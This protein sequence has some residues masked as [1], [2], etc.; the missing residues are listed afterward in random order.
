[1]DI[2]AMRS[3]LCDDIS[4]QNKAAIGFIRP[5]CAYRLVGD[6]ADAELVPDARNAQPGQGNGLSADRGSRGRGQWS[7]DQARASAA[8]RASSSFVATSPR[9]VSTRSSA[10]CHRS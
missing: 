8:A 5:V 9:R 1:M 7:C 10:A 6:A 4:G 2:A 3:I